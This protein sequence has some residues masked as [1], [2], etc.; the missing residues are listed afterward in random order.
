MGRD[1]DEDAAAEEA[2]TEETGGLGSML[3]GLLG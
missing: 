3:G 2:L 1:D